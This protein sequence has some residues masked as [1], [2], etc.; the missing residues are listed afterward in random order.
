M[1]HERRLPMAGVDAAGEHRA[2]IL[3]NREEN[4]GQD[5]EHRRW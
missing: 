5:H 1:A 2:I 3:T 4:C